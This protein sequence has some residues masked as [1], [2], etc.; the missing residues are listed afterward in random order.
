IDSPPTALRAAKE[1]EE[2]TYYALQRTTDSE[3]FGELQHIFKEFGYHYPYWIVTGGKFLYS[4]PERD[5]ILPNDVIETVLK[6]DMQWRAYGGDLSLLYDNHD[7]KGWL[8]STATHQ[9]LVMPSDVNPIYD[10]LEDEVSSEVQRIYRMQCS[11]LT[12]QVNPRIETDNSTANALVR[13]S[14]IRGKVGVAKGVHIGGSL[15]EENAVELVNETDITKLIR[16][17]SV[18]G[19]PRIECMVRRTLLGTSIGIHAFL[20][21]DFLDGST[22][23]SGFMRAVMAHHVESNSGELQPSTREMRYFVMYVT[24]RERAAIKALD[25][26]SDKEKYQELQKVFGHFG[27][28]YPYSILLGGRLVYKAYPKD[29]SGVWSS[30]DG[31]DTVDLLIMKGSLEYSFTESVD[32]ETIGGSSIFKGCQDWI[33]SVRTNQ[34]RAQFKSLRPIYELLEEEHRAEV[35]RLYDGEKEYSDDLPE[36]PK[37]LHFDGTEAKDQVIEFSKDKTDSRMI[38]LRNFA[39]QPSIELSKRYVMGFKDIGYHLSMDIETDRELPGSSGFVF[40]SEGAYK[41]R[42]I[43][44]EHHCSKTK[45][46]YDVAYVTYKEVFNSFTQLKEDN[47]AN[48]KLKSGGAVIKTNQ[49][50]SKKIVTNAIAKSLAKSERWDFI[51]RCVFQGGDSVLLLLNDVK[52]W[53]DTV[54][55]SQ[56]VTQRRGLKPVYELLDEEQRHKVQQ[57][58]DN[59]IAEDIRIPYEYPFELT[60]YEE[61]PE[62]D[63]KDY[64]EPICVPTE[65]LFETLL[66]QVFPDSNAAI[67]FCRSTCTDY[68]FSVIEKEATDRIVC[69]YCSQSVLSENSLS[70]LND[71]QGEREHESFCQ[72]GVMLFENDEALWQFQKLTNV[73]E[74]MHNHELTSGET[75]SHR[76]LKSNEQIITSSTAPSEVTTRITIKPVA[77]SPVHDQDATNA[78]YMR[79]GDIVRLENMERGYREFISI[80]GVKYESFANS[81]TKDELLELLNHKLDSCSLWF[82]TFVCATLYSSKCR[83]IVPYPLTSDEGESEANRIRDCTETVTD[84]YDYV[85]S[86]DVVLFESQELVKENYR[87]YLRFKYPN[88]DF[89]H[90]RGLNVPS[91]GFNVSSRGFNVLLKGCGVISRSFGVISSVFNQLSKAFGF[92]IPIGVLSRGFGVISRGFRILSRDL[93][94]L[95]GD[96]IKECRYYIRPTNQYAL[97]KKRHL[98]K[99]Y[100]CSNERLVKEYLE[101]ASTGSDLYSFELGQAYMY[102]LPMLGVNITQALKYLKQATDKFEGGAFYELGKL[103]WRVEEYQEAMEMYEAA[104]LLSEK[105]VCRILGDIYHTGLSI[106]QNANGYAIPQDYKLAFMHYSIGG[107]LGD[108]T[109]ALNIGKY[110]EEGQIEDFGIDHSKALRWYEYVRNQFRIPEAT[111]AVGRI[112]HTMANSTKDPLEK[113]E[114]RREAYSA[115]EKVAMDHPYA[116]FMVAVY[117]LNG[118]GC[119]QSDPMQGFELLLSLVETGVNIALYGIAKCYEQGVGVE[120]DLAKASAY[121]ELAVQMDAQ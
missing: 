64:P 44:R 34:A 36:I 57:T 58:Y 15:S 112:K 115:F 51:D 90:S 11:Q 63:Q 82:D 7:I 69:I 50:L 119:G 77:E 16:L 41:E 18:A 89:V 38:M 22:E 99:T 75:R 92:L 70:D 46:A 26:K 106:P 31:T 101:K 21:S 83:K 67:Q 66:V 48:P 23:D 103:Y 88:Y 121:H 108:A 91:R 80:S 71:E 20:P 53:I 14:Q 2:A 102:G 116:K 107:I 12:L 10:L 29:P 9:D 47:Q 42:S 110:Y 95:S 84:N 94:E 5:D 55:Y 56:A 78:Q 45:A 17:A 24:Y 13:L 59:I 39:G 117:Y 118:W 6:S 96:S 111:L 87:L 86:N 85:R 79:Y 3:K 98:S 37:G 27:Y 113:D 81:L 74:S 60:R 93:N 54:E 100:I 25:M 33:D 105:K 4:N 52:R 72:W 28:Y 114:L 97:E 68:G 104:A 120:R 61:R 49:G 73:D 32:I 35:L 62:K 30:K 8:E 109:A 19:K 65:E 1:F 40:G 43:I 76:A